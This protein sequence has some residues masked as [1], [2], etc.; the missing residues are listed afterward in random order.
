MIERLLQR[1]KTSGRIDD[2]VAT[3]EKRYAGYLKDTLPIVKHLIDDRVTVFPVSCGD[4]FT[5]SKELKSIDKHGR[6]RRKVVD[7]IQR[8]AYSMIKKT[9]RQYKADYKKEFF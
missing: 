5:L 8:E 9:S 3:Y 2:N 4:Q 1:S 7:R 6:K